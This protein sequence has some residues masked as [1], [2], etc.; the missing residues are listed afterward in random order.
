MTKKTIIIS[1]IV[2]AGVGTYMYYSANTKNA[3]AAIIKK[4]GKV[5]SS[6]ESLASERFEKPFLK[7]WS[8]AL[9][10]GEQTFTYLGKMYDANYGTSI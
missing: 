8:A 7:A 6:I 10:K 5:T 3:Y 4:L 9:K 1:L 2:V